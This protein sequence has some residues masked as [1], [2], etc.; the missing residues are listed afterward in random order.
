VADILETRY[1][2]IS[3]LYVKLF[4]RNYGNSPENFDPL[5]PVTQGHFGTDTN[6]LAA[7]NFPLVIHS[8]HGPIS[9][10]F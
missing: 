2:Q 4:G 6:R 9:Y 10:R 7:Y 1:C 3:S 8:N 5:C